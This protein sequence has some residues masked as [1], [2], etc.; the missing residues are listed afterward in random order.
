MKKKKSEMIK[1]YI[2]LLVT[3][4]LLIL[5]FGFMLAKSDVYFEVARNIDIFTRVYKEIA[6]NYVDD[7]SPEQF[8]RAGIRGMLSTLDPY[9]VFIDEKRKDDIDLLTNGKYGGVGVSIGLRD[10]R[11]TILEIMDGYAAQ[12][13]GIMIG[14]IILS[15]DSVEINLDNF[16]DISSHVKGKPGTFVEISILRNTKDTLL[17]NLLREEI[18]IKNISFCDFYPEESNNVYIKLIG[19]GRASGEELKNAVLELKKK[20]EIK[21][22]ILDLRNNPGG[23]LDAAVDIS[24]KFLNKGDLVVSTRGRDTSN[25]K[26]YYSQQEPIL[27]GIPLLVLVNEGSASASEIVAGAIQDHDRGVILGTKSFGKGLVQTISPLSYNTSLKIT[28]SKYYTPSGRSI[29]KIDYSKKNPVFTKEEN[30][31]VTPYL[32]DTKRVVYSS[33]GI[34]PDSVMNFEI[35]SELM[36]ELFAKGLIFRFATEY[37]DANKDLDFNKL[38]LDKIASDFDKFLDREKFEFQGKG[39][40]L[41]NNF[42]SEVKN[43]KNYALIKN[44]IGKIK[45]ELSQ[46]Y[47]E[48]LSAQRE[49]LKREIT[50]ELSKRYLAREKSLV[51]KLRNDKLIT[52]ALQMLQKEKDYYRLLNREIR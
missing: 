50:D 17:F 48:E 13:Q 35:K 32:T 30:Q 20:K 51:V 7:I 1:K 4:P 14:D 52:A 5:V 10:D 27:D 24:G 26:Y 39:Y 8:L 47:L 43:L 49:L 15:V 3:A 28:T 38:P 21:S 44:E 11:V 37:Y 9:T 2:W 46:I 41:I 40:A 36:T 29:Q 34:T 22:I 31:N 6:F 25:V 18:I 23:L 12:R 33:G 45:A 16:D 19:F 42:D